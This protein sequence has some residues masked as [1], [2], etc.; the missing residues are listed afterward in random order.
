MVA[1]FAIVGILK[2][3]DCALYAYMAEHRGK[4]SWLSIVAVLVRLQL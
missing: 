1:T 2:V 3:I 4:G